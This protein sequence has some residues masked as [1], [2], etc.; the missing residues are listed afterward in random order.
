M[1][2]VMLPI[3]AKGKITGILGGR[4]VV[5]RLSDMGFIPG[6]EVKVVHSHAS[7]N[8]GHGGPLVVEIKDTR[9]AL[10]RGV[11]MKIMVQESMVNSTYSGIDRE[12]KRG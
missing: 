12:P 2:L 8:H 7:P 4:R 1:P 3:G 6:V 5:R 9:I 10:G 11:A